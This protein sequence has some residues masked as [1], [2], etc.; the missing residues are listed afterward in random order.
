M[1]GAPPAQLNSPFFPFLPEDQRLVG[2]PPLRVHL[3]VRRDA[4]LVSVLGAGGIGGVP[5][6]EKPGF[7]PRYS[8]PHFLLS[9]LSPL[10]SHLRP[11][12]RPNGLIYQ[13]FR[14]QF[15]A[16]SIFQSEFPAPIG[17]KAG[18][19]WGSCGLCWW[20]SLLLPS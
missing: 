3:P 20:L 19:L 8:E 9:P 18:V 4:D 16:F 13:K 5:P 7:S 17:G 1:C 2:V 6:Q 12:C 11:L 10:P 14:N 15:L